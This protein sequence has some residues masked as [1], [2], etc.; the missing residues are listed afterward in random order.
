MPDGSYKTI[1]IYNKE[2]TKERGKKFV[3]AIEQA[4][5]EKDKRKRKLNQHSGDNI[6]LKELIELYIDEN[7]YL[8]KKQTLYNKT[9]IIIN[10]YIIT[11]FPENKAIDEC[12]STRT[13]EMF[14]K[15]I[16][17]K[18]LS[19]NR[20]NKIMTAFKE[21]LEFASDHEYLSFELFRK[22]KNILKNIK[23]NDD[24]EKKKN[25]YFGQMK[26]GINFIHLLMKMIFGNFSLK[27]FIWVHLELESLFL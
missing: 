27:L 5:I 20:K 23:N 11:C 14:R 4:E 25:Y 17:N 26:N 15:N 3:Q 9:I 21:I 6:T 8:L 24:G 7:K 16:L 13:I 12:F 22:L 18:V 10:K 1:S 2:W 19:P